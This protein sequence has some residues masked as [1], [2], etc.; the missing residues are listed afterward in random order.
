MINHAS[1]ALS[2]PMNRRTLLER[3]A[4][5][6][7]GAAAG[8]ALQPGPA[9]GQEKPQPPAAKAAAPA[10]PV[11]LHPPVVQVKGGKLRGFRDGKANSFL[12]IRY[13]EAERFEQ[14]KP[15][16]PWDGI[17]NAQAWGP[18]CPIP[19]HDRASASTSSSSRIATGCRT[20]TAR[21]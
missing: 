11:N 21:S 13:A 1:D 16:Q 3:G 19:R 6:V 8:L 15:V 7:G 5:L 20:S 10:E 9:L 2:G 4:A 18:V 12:G 14:P 17:K